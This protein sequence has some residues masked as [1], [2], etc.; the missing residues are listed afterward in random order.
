[1]T[2]KITI[3]EPIIEV[4]SEELQSMYF[5]ADEMTICMVKELLKQLKE[6]KENHNGTNNLG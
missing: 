2:H 3:T 5:I 4:M 6:S 1:M